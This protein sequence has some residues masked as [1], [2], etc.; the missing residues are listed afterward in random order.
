MWPA[1][2]RT[3]S[4]APSKSLP[5]GSARPPEM[6]HQERLGD[7]VERQPVLRDGKAVPLLRV[8]HVGH[9]QIL[10]PHRRDDLVGLGLLDARIVGALADQQR[11][12]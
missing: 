2:S 6:G 1:P 3:S 12:A 4:L 5:I 7:G 9:G 8:Q 10:G 11:L